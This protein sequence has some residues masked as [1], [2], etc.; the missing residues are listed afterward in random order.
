MTGAATRHPD[1][2]LLAAWERWLATDRA[3]EATYGTPGDTDEDDREWN[4]LL[5]ELWAI[6]KEIATM[7]AN[8]DAGLALKLRLLFVETAAR[9]S[10]SYTDGHRVF[11]RH[12]EPDDEMLGETSAK[13]LWGAIQDVERMAA[14]AAGAGRGPAVPA[15]ARLVGKLAADFRLANVVLLAALRH[16]EDYDSVELDAIVGQLRRLSGRLEKRAGQADRLNVAGG[17]GRA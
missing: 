15:M 6:E 1:A 7:P 9:N 2:G 13:L 5:R 12:G 17:E 14:R 11:L 4:S 3:I 8:T 10:S 16:L